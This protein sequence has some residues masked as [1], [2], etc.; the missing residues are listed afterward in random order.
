MKTPSFSIFDSKADIYLP[1]FNSQTNESAIREFSHL[2]NTSS[3][4][5]G[6]FPEDYS[7]FHRG[8]D[9]DETGLH[10]Q[11]QSPHHLANG[12]QLITPT[13]IS[14]NDPQPYKYETRETT[15]T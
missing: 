6:N 2:V 3:G 15:N 5:F 1:P 10:E 4:H 8:Y 7:L 9:N 14:G 13:D 11:L 12:I